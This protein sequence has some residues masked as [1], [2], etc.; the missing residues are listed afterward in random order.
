MLVAFCISDAT[1]G[2]TGTG[3][4]KERG[5]GGFF[6]LDHFALLAPD[7]VAEQRV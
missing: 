7:F 5:T 6:T 2:T 3:D 1:A 4:A